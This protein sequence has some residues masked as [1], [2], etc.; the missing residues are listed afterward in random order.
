MKSLE[1]IGQM[2]VVKRPEKNVE[3]IELIELFTYKENFITKES[4]CKV[5]ICARGDKTLT[6]LSVY[7]P[8]AGQIALRIFACISLNFSVI[9]QADISTAFLYGRSN[10]YIYYEL[11]NGHK[12]KEGV[13]K[14][15]YV[16]LQSA[17]MILLMSFYKN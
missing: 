10:N 8:V 17:G 14:G 4:Y 2:K 7:S 1:D 9:K 16:T 5:R 15:R 12:L 11:P 13:Y 3:V 6:N